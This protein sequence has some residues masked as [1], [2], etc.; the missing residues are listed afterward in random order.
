MGT[1]TGDPDEQ[2]RFG[3]N[4]C[5][6][7]V[8]NRDFDAVIGIG[9]ISAWPKSCGIDRRITWVGLGP[10][11]H[12]SHDSAPIVTFEHFV[13]LD[14]KGPLLEDFAPALARRMYEGGVRTL[15]KSYSPQ[16]QAEAETVLRQMLK[17]ESICGKSSPNPKR[18]GCGE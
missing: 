6:G 9:G 13:L 16:E 10:T 14:E 17:R 3:I 7:E 8:R 18:G 1:H 2:G 11:K 4:D 5:M 15:L 12:P